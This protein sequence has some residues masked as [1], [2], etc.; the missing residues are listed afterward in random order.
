VVAAAAGAVLGRAWHAGIAAAAVATVGLAFTARWPAAR[1]RSW[2]F[3]VRE[4]DVLIKYGVWWR[5]V[6]VVPHARIQHVDTTHGPLARALGLAS[7]VLFTAGT[8]GAV[9]TIPG[10]STADA[11]GLRDRLAELGRVGEAV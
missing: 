9:L 8:I 4:Q 5:R 10:L 3:A 11:D 2:G 1:Y 6:S 7:V